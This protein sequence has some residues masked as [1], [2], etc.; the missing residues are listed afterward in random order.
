[1]AGSVASADAWVVQSLKAAKAPK[2]VLSAAKSVLLFRELMGA[3]AAALVDE[4]TD[5]PRPVRWLLARAL[6]EPGSTLGDACLFLL[7]ASRALGE[8]AGALLGGTETA[9]FWG[10]DARQDLLR[11]NW[12]Y[13]WAPTARGAKDW[14]AAFQGW[15]EETTLNALAVQQYLTLANSD[16]PK[17][18]VRGLAIGAL[19]SMRRGMTGL[20]FPVAEGLHSPV[21][22]FPMAKRR[23]MAGLIAD[24]RA[25]ARMWVLRD[26]ACRINRCGA[27]RTLDDDE[28]G[29]SREPMLEAIYG[30]SHA[31]LGW[32]VLA[33]AMRL[34]WPGKPGLLGY[35]PG[36][37]DE[38]HLK[39][40]YRW[41][42]RATLDYGH[43]QEH[44][45]KGIQGDWWLPEP[46]LIGSGMLHSQIALA[47]DELWR[48][49]RREA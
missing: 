23:G 7:T 4:V 32:V 9:W 3:G 18:V 20:S 44:W 43:A 5:D 21:S 24:D 27:N 42:L 47:M 37:R 29:A 19:L 41:A 6:A 14:M 40:G 12:T 15:R 16:E 39:D 8:R 48:V 30:A 26:L 46:D 31:P 2:G 49:E 13:A 36:T 28:G 1:M 22:A 33:L 11:A 34:G 25:D 10:D 45:R 17:T 38:V 35:L